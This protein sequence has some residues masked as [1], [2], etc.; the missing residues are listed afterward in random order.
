MFVNH[1]VGSG[2]QLSVNG[3]RY[4]V[5]TVREN[6]HDVRS[7]VAMSHQTALFARLKKSHWQ[8]KTS[9]LRRRVEEIIIDERVSH[10]QEM[11]KLGIKSITVE[12]QREKGIDVKLATDLI[13]GAVDNLYD[14]AIVVSSD[15]DL[16]PAID[17]TRGKFK[18]KIEYVGFS[19]LNNDNLDKSTRPLLA[20]VS[21]SDVQRILTADDLKPF[22]MNYQ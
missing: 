13:V 9:K 2:R 8:I 15:S 22:A 19:I 10:Y 16:V 20:I 21:K 4:Y 1:L 3:K 11:R 7:R 6:E 14:T 12:R 18:K 17:W 5:G